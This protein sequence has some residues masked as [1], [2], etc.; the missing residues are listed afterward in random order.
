MNN[1]F[2]MN[3]MVN[4]MNNLNTNLSNNLEN[5]IPQMSQSMDKIN[6]NNNINNNKNE[7][8]ESILRNN[9]VIK[10][11]DNF[12]P[13]AIVKNISFDATSGLKVILKVTKETTYKEL[14]LK[15]V[16]KIGLEE[17]VIN[18]DIIFLFNGGKMDVNSEDNIA[19]LPDF[20]AITVIDQKNIIGA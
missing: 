10:D 8:K 4:S 12:P 7:E 5:N 16:N 2:N 11:A 17:S 18:K 6:P 1:N 20:S 3:N 19:K 13:G 9:K 14:I 15:Y